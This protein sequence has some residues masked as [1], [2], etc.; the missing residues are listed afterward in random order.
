MQYTVR[1]QRRSV[2]VKDLLIKGG[3]VVTENE[4]RVADILTAGEVIKKIGQDIPVREGLELI[5]ARGKLV[6]PGGVDVHT[7]LCL[8]TGAAVSSDDFYT[9]TV[10]AAWGGTTTIV[11]HPGFGPQGCPPDHQIKKYHAQAE[12]RAV[13]DYGFHG[14]LQHVDDAVLSGMEALIAEGITSYKV[15]LTY[16]FKLADDALYRVLEQAK[17]LGLLIAVH[18]END[19]V[20]NYLRERFRREGKLSARYHPRSR[21]PECEAEAVNRMILLA[22]MTADA[23]LYIVHLTNEQGLEYIKHA[24]ARGQQNIYA[25]TCPQYLFLDES[26]YEA[27]GDEG[28]KYIICPP[29]RTVRDQERLWEGL[30]EDIDVVATDHCPFFFAFQKMQGK[31]DFTRCPSGAPGIEER[32]LLLLSEGVMKKR[33]SLRRFTDICSANPAKLFG[34]YPKK[35]VIREGSDADIVI[36]DPDRKTVLRQQ[37]LHANVDYCAY[38]GFTLTGHPVCTV[39]RG[40]V[41]LRDGIFSGKAGRGKFIKRGIMEG[42]Q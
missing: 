13:I 30:K 25:E 21:P 24:R 36:I 18:P 27:P 6:L 38:E 37:D 16:G 9:G 31:D 15:Y 23:P 34:M 41:I 42:L 4:E 20:V 40:E 14:V 39:S 22:R 32:L 26:R 2:T 19:G 12:G 3:L 33:I 29:L 7:H 28:L 11:D 10:A 17:R 35:G 5:D 8:D 1:Q